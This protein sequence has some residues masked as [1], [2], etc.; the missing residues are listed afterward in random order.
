MCPTFSM[1]CFL[2]VHKMHPELPVFDNM[3]WDPC[4]V[5]LKWDMLQLWNS[6]V[7]MPDNRPKD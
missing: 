7:G 4:E 3:G 1:H 5:R 2:D 6:F